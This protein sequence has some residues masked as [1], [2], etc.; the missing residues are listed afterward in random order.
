MW[1]SHHY[2]MTGSAELRKRNAPEIEKLPAAAKVVTAAGDERHATAVMLDQ[3][4]E[5]G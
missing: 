5:R 1:Q 2:T 4:V 3:P